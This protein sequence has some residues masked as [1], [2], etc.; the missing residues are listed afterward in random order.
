[1]IAAVGGARPGIALSHD[2]AP[3]G[4]LREPHHAWLLTTLCL[5]RRR[6]EVCESRKRE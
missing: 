3:E 4:K 1:M 2:E 5:A 6:R